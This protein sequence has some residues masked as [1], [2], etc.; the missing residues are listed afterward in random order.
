MSKPQIIY[1]AYIRCFFVGTRFFVENRGKKHAFHYLIARFL[2]LRAFPIFSE[3]FV[4][5]CACKQSRGRCAWMNE[6]VILTFTA[7][8]KLYIIIIIVILHNDELKCVR[9]L[10]LACCVMLFC[11]RV[12]ESYT[13]SVKLFVTFSFSRLF[14][15]CL[16]LVTNSCA[17]IKVTVCCS[18]FRSVHPSTNML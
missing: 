10:T 9:Y 18:F 8:S 6:L 17:M 5:R 1:F 13:K 16:T 14:S 7:T 4:V 12:C 15:V 2:S 11:A 3:A